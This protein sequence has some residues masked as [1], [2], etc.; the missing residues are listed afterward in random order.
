[1][2]GIW[3]N[4]YKN[5]SLKR[6]LVEGGYYES[7]NYYFY[8]TDHLGNNRILTDATASVVQSTQYYLF[9]TSIADATGTSTQSYKYNRKELD[10]RNGLNMYDYSARW[11]DDSGSNGREVL[12]DQSVRVC[13]E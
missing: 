11:K 3:N 9:G 5:N 12:F 6:I 1:V 10:A 4:I 8:I 7:G 2:R 13:R